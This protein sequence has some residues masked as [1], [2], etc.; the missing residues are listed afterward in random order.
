[1][2]WRVIEARQTVHIRI[3]DDPDAPPHG[4]RSGKTF[5]QF[6]FARALSVVLERG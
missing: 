2:S 3:H 5:E 6:P 4:G 1:V